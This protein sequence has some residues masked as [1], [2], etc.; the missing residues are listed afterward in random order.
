MTEQLSTAQHTTIIRF[1]CR[2][3]VSKRMCNKVTQS[4]PTLRDPMD[5]SPPG[6]SVHRDSPGK[7]TRVGCHAFLQGIFPT[8]GSNPGLLCC[9][10]ILFH[11]SHQRSPFPSMWTPYFMAFTQLRNIYVFLGVITIKPSLGHDI[12]NNV[13]YV[14]VHLRLSSFV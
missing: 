2:L 4:C 8:Q 9:R 10:R 3:I 1:N 11:L 14:P 5:C 7:N 13:A 6:S 12:A